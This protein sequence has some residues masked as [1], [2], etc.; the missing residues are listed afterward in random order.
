MTVAMV[1]IVEGGQLP[2]NLLTHF[3]TD[4]GVDTMHQ[5]VLNHNA[6]EDR[7]KTMNDTNV[8]I[9]GWLM[10]NNLKIFLYISITATYVIMVHE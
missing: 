4:K 1:L 5:E 8:E 3:P 10:Q 2:I 6:K 7:V 9:R